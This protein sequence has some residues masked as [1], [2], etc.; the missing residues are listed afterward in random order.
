MN[1]E[2]IIHQEELDSSEAPASKR[3][4]GH[5]WRRAFKWLA[6][7]VIVVGGSVALFVGI[8][9]S[10]ISVNPFGFG[11]LKGEGQGRVNIMML[12]I[13]DPGHAGG[14]LSDTN[15]L[16]SVDTRK[17]Q[18]AVISIPRDT[19]VKVP[20]YGQ[21]K[22]NTANANGGIPVA[23]QV[24]ESSLGVPVHY[25][26][27]AN[28]TGLSDVVD[29]VGGVDVNNATLLVDKSYPCEKNQYKECGFRLAPGKH[30]LDG[31]TALQYVR[32][33]KGTCGDDFGRA[34]R[35]QEVM[36][37]IR[38]KATAAGTI[39]NPIAVG[40]LIAA[41]G[42]N[43]ETDLSVNNLM[44][45]NELTKQTPK[46]SIY[47]VV[48]NTKEGGFL[49]QLP[50]SDIVPTS[51][52]FNDIREFVQQIFVR[53]PIWSEHP[54][55][56]IQNGT[57]TV[58][59]GG[60]FSGKLR[61]DGKDLSVLAVANALTHDNATTQIIDYTGGKKLHALAYLEGILKV[62]SKPPTVPLANPPADI[63]VILGDDYAASTKSPTTSPSSASTPV[64]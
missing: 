31:A 2:Y 22:I 11:Q 12:G 38:T 10:K 32:C 60:R 47:N 49:S 19:R 54:T 56:I 7:T 16:V 61:L 57:S 41:A 59:L 21:A 23:K 55:V 52:N 24:F 53:A 13:G 15:I 5:Y 6:I 62:K 35:Q 1:E 37:A 40:K 44:R 46:S 14:N 63:V 8:N 25:Y 27:R 4:T 39:A 48:F 50:G 64:Q 26:V 28:F 9:L 45:L 51:G 29:A 20:G 58:G 36:Q 3:P 18:V 30:H 43:I 34:E 33:R 17:H 42:N